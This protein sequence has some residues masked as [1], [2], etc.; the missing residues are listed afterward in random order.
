M[1]RRADMIEPPAHVCRKRL[2]RR[3]LVADRGMPTIL[4]PRNEFWKTRSIRVILPQGV[5]LSSLQAEK[6][7]Y[8]NDHGCHLLIMVR[9]VGS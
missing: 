6:Q 1:K 5:K 8:K 2:E 4:C 7:C 3:V 9:S